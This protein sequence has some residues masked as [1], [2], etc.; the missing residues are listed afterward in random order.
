MSN[1]LRVGV[2]GAAGVVGSACCAGFEAA[3]R[4]VLRHD[5][6]LGTS[7]SVVL[8][9]P[10]VFVCVPTPAG[11]SGRLNMSI[12]EAVLRDLAGAGYAGMV[13][14]KSTSTPGTTDRLAAATGLDCCFVPEFLR[15]RCA[16]DDFIHKH[17]LLARTPCVHDV[18]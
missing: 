11:D 4:T 5:L 10:V 9:A 16:V 12:V 18:D 17:T 15:E 2:V 8:P 7:L 3:G 1:E 6:T 14:I 13:A